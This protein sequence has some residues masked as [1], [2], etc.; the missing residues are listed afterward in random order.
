MDL[1]K[2]SISL[3]QSETIKIMNNIH[4]KDEEISKVLKEMITKN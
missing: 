1:L 4:S 2:L 3:N